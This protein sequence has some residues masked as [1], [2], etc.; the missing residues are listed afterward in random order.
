MGRT[1]QEKKRIACLGFT[2]NPPHVG[3]LWMA[4]RAL[5]EAGVE[6]VWLIPCGSH[7]FAK[8]LFSKRHRLAMAKLLQ[9]PRI[10]VSTIEMR[11]TGPS[12]TIDTV[13][14]LKKKFPS[15]SFVWVVGSDIISSKGYR[16]WMTWDSLSRLLPFWVIERPGYP[17]RGQK[18]DSCFQVLP[19]KNP[20]RVSST[21]VR[22]Y[23]RQHR[24]LA[25]LVPRKIELYIKRND[26]KRFV[27]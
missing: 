22:E 25:N 1:R 19:G 24:S 23:M 7:S 21:L 9:M 8:L 20:Y 2:A 3:H 6:E 18:I 27:L 11:R 15:Y 26:L 16:K 5:R 12:Y 4:K 10:R 17:L 14:Q 13:R